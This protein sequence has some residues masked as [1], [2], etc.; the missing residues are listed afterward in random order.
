MSQRRPLFYAKAFYFL[1]FGAWACLAPFLSVYYKGLGFSGSQI[2]F[3]ASISPLTTLIAASFWS[4]LADATQHHKR[5]LLTAVAGSAF[6]ILALS[7]VNMYWLMIPIVACSAFFTAPIIPLID[8]STLALLGD[9][10]DQ[11]G[12][13]RFWGAVGWGLTG[14]VTGW[15]VGNF[16][17]R[18]AFACFLIFA[19]FLFFSGF[20]VKVTRSGQTP[21]FWPELR[22]LITN[23]VWIL[24]LLVVF[25]GGSG[26]MV[27]DYFLFIFM[28]EIKASSALM[29]ISLT[30][31]TLSE[32]PVLFFSSQL[33]RKWGP[34][35]LLIISLSACVLRTFGY[36][37]S[38]Q[39]WQALLLQLLH[40]LSFSAM[41]IA[42]VSFANQIA[43]EGLG[44][45][46][47]SLFTG[48]A[49]GLG[50]IT[51]AILGGALLDRF[52][53]A[54]MFR[55]TSMYVLAGL[56]LFIA[57]GKII[58]PLQQTRP[59]STPSE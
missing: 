44:T 5:I 2:G 1:Y 20:G 25:I 17:I 6:S 59:N 10:Q 47:L 58:T 12:K 18:W 28:T 54:G 36:S 42:G 21:L 16:G 41:W 46:A 30:V 37:I 8:N 49:M 39:P 26:L 23:R 24:F 53:G 15:V 27:I 48:T 55:V 7:L 29:G 33:L 11:Y 43:P 9:R 50:G 57:A 40:G 52:G 34:R 31:A 45:T 13:Q 51:G 38:T 14:P 56:V 35:G 4:G 19:V 32:L 22:R 3:L